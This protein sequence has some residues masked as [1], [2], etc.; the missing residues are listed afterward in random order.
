VTAPAHTRDCESST[1]RLPIPA[2]R[3]RPG[4]PFSVAG[5]LRGQIAWARR[6]TSRSIPSI[7]ALQVEVAVAAAPP[8]A[9]PSCGER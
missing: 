3:T 9:G 6:I 8:N 7:A 1:A 4:A 2:N 5:N